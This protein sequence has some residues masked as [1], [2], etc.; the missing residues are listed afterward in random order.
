[1]NKFKALGSKFI[2]C[3]KVV[4]IGQVGIKKCTGILNLHVGRE[5]SNA[6]MYKQPGREPW[7]ARSQLL[8]VDVVAAFNEAGG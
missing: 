6:I 5:A 7:Y 2:L 3:T 8:R 1:M 4:D